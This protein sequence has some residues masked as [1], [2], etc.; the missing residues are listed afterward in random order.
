MHFRGILESSEGLAD[1]RIVETAL[2]WESGNLDFVLVLTLNCFVTLG[3][4]LHLSES[5]CPFLK[6]SRWAL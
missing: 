4:S 2:K 1:V 3:K 5:L 6:G